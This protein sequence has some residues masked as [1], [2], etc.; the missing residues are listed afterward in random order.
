MRGEIPITYVP[1]RNTFLLVLA[2]AYLESLVLDRIENDKV[3]PSEIEA[4]IFMAA[5]YLD[6]SGYPD[7]R[8]EFFEKINELISLA[9]KVGTEYGIEMRIE[10]PLLRLGKKEIVELF[11]SRLGSEYEDFQVLYSLRNQQAHEPSRNELDKWISVQRFACD[12]LGRVVRKFTP[13]HKRKSLFD[14]RDTLLTPREGTE[15]KVSLLNSICE[16]LR[17]YE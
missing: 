6:Y 1:M 15:L 14:N 3:K 16:G 11:K 13:L 2:A 10:T 5:N 8:P 12:R 7:C 4:K 17:N 9:S